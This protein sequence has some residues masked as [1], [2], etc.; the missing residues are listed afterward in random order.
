MSTKYFAPS[1]HAGN[2]ICDEILRPG[3]STPTAWPRLL[4]PFVFFDGFKHFLQVEV[5]AS[6]KDDFEL[7]EGWVHSRMRLLIRA[8]GNMVDVRPWPK[9]LRP[10]PPS[11]NAEGDSDGIVGP[12][13]FYFLGLAKKRAQTTYQYG[14]PLIIPQSKV[15]LTPAVNEF[16]HKVKDWADRKP[17]MDVFVKHVL[18]RQI[19]QWATVRKVT[20]EKTSVVNGQVIVEVTG[21][22]RSADQMAA[23]GGESNEEPAAKRVLVVA[24]NLEGGELDEVGAAAVAAVER[25]EDLVD[26]AAGGEGGGMGPEETSEVALRSSIVALAGS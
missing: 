21:Q 13:C 10:P 9:A 1:K 26:W 11:E 24:G 5:T 16:A 7:W 3:A 17:G 8:V 14:Q 20:D 6:S 18:Q 4:E 2:T 25:H 15:D 22:K 19:P 23:N 12:R